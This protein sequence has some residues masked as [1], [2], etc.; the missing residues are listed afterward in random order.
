MWPIGNGYS[1][2]ITNTR[3]ILIFVSAWFVSDLKYPD[4][5]A[6]GIINT[7]VGLSCQNVAHVSSKNNLI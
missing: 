5:K 1:L 4:F 2:Q 7:I 6:V 3:L